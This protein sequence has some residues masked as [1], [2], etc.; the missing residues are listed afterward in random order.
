MGRYYSG[1]IQ[2]KFWFGVQSSC[3]ASRFGGA[4]SEPSY[5]NYYFDEDHLQEIES[6]IKKIEN[7]IDVKKIDNF[8]EGKNGYNDEALS[9]A[10]ITR[11]ELEEYA[12][13]ILGRKIFNC[14]KQSGVCSF[15]AEL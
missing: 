5:I 13:L 8:F 15:D 7:S 2:G 1:D 10:G 6:E 11:K 12:D 9:E 3:A 14:V 4:E